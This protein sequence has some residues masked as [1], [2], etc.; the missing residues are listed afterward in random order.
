MLLRFAVVPIRYRDRLG[1]GP[2]KKGNL[3]QDVASTGMDWQEKK[4]KKK[5]TKTSKREGT[6]RVVSDR[7]AKRRAQQRVKERK[8]SCQSDW[9]TLCSFRSCWPAQHS[10]GRIRRRPYYSR[11]VADDLDD[12][13]RSRTHRITPSSLIQ[14]D[15]RQ[16]GRRRRRR[17]STTA[18]AA[19]AERY[20]LTREADE[21]SAVVAGRQGHR[22]VGTLRLAG[23][24]GG[25]AR[26]AAIIA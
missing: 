1:R 15:N 22:G 16:E 18:A 24:R 10:S 21:R 12:V 7:E 23:R 17:R 20:K 9:M 8:L 13:N 14:S 25:V 3:F 26:R 2:I 5:V 4:T 19:A 11:F 6:T